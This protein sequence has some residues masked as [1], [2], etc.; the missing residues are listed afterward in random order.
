MG[1]LVRKLRVR[2]IPALVLDEPDWETGWETVLR[3]NTHLQP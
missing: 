1:A 2:T 3:A